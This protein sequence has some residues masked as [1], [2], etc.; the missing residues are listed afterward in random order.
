MTT[1]PRTSQNTSLIA[2]LLRRIANGLREAHIRRARR[3]ALADLLR[4]PEAHLDD[5]G[6]NRQDIVEA[7][8]APRSATPSLET[9]READ[10]PANSDSAS[11]CRQ[12]CD[13]DMGVMA[14]GASP[15]P[16]RLAI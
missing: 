1:E 13:V 6:I 4:M 5:L 10:R 9:L 11:L 16:H 8:T 3:L 2:T 7:F 12:A 15:Q 14:I